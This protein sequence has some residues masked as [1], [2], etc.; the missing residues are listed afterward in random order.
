M[1]DWNIVPKTGSIFEQIYALGYRVLSHANGMYSARNPHGA[2]IFSARNS[3]DCWT[4][5]Y[6]HRYQLPPKSESM[7]KLEREVAELIELLRPFAKEYGEF[8]HNYPDDASVDAVCGFKVA[9]FHRAYE[10]VR[11]YDDQHRTD[12]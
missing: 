3:D 11:A 9:D 4:F 1:S 5:C 8:L 6:Q 2:E 7:A 12:R 10:K